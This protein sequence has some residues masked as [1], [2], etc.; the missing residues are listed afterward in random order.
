MK[1]I[2]IALLAGL[3]LQ[4]APAKALGI[5]EFIVYVFA[6]K[7]FLCSRS[8]FSVFTSSCACQQEQE[9]CYACA[10]KVVEQ[11][12]KAAKIKRT[13]KKIKKMQDE[14]ELAGIVN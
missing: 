1:R 11:Q 13:A 2:K 14:Q 6:V 5:G 7:G 4:A 12:K 3:L 10:C 9:L 8:L